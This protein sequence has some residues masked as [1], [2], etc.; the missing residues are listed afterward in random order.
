MKY[1]LLP[2]ALLLLIYITA[3]SP[4]EAYGRVVKT[5]DGDTFDV[6]LQ[7]HDSRITEDQIRIRLADIYCPEIP[8]SKC[9]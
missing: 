1:L 8:R 3:A 7:D 4:D 9:L 2:F 6:L 5:V